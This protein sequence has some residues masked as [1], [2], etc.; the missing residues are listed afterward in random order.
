[1]TLCTQKIS[2]NEENTQTYV[3]P[4]LK[5]LCGLKTCEATATLIQTDQ[6]LLSHPR[7]TSCTLFSI[8]ISQKRTGL[9]RGISYVHVKLNTDLL[10]RKIVPQQSPILLTFLL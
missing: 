1:M 3:S 9:E 8:V 2:V 10:H 5:F 7:S 6:L 4:P